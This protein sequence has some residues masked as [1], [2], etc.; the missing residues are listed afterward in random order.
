MTDRQH[1]GAAARTP[2]HASSQQPP[3]VP[4]EGAVHRLRPGVIEGAGTHTTWRSRQLAG[5]VT[6]SD[7]AVGRQWCTTGDRAPGGQCHAPSGAST[8]LMARSSASAVRSSADRAPEPHRRTPG[9]RP[10]SRRLSPRRHQPHETQHLGP[11]RRRTRRELPARRA[12]RHHGAQVP[13]FLRHGS[14]DSRTRRASATVSAGVGMTWTSAPPGS[15]HPL[16]SGPVTSPPLLGTTRC[17]PAAS[18]RSPSAE[19]LLP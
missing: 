5:F 10:T 9:T 19:R 16:G 12:G 18:H 13:P 6:H 14:S 2:E 11:P 17:N 3:G 1:V 8:A 15:T 4:D 7:D